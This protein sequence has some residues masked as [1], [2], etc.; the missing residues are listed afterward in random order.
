L[1]SAFSPKSETRKVAILGSTGSIGKQALEVIA[2]AKRFFGGGSA[3][4]KKQRNTAYPNR[5]LLSN[6]TAS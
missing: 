2:F 6:R 1:Q 4:R 3:V 5:R